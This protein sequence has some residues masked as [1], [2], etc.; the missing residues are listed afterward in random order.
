M[1]EIK[2]LAP[3]Y[4]EKFDIHVNPYLTYDQIQQIISAVIK[5]E[6]WSERQQNIDIGVLYHTTDLTK[7][8]I[9][10]IGHDKLLQSG[11]I[12]AVLMRVSNVNKIYEGVEYTES[13]PRALAQII[14]ILPEKMKE[15]EEVIKRGSNKK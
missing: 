1:K 6:N 2:A 10:E 5:M 9:E 7:E 8:Q 15:I 14:K 13:T 11:L 3:V 4:I 12:D